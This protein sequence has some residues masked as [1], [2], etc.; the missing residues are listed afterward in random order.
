VNQK[1]VAF[2]IYPA[3]QALD[4][5][6]PMDA[7]AAARVSASAR[8]AVPGYDLITVGLSPRS[9]PTES[10]LLLTPRFTIR[11]APSFDTLIIPGGRGMRDPKVGGVVGRWLQGLPQLPRR[12]AA[13]CTGVFGL[14]SSGLLDGRRVTTHWRHA[15]E[16]AARFPSVQVHDDSLFLKDG[17]FYTS[18]GIT[19]G[20]DLSLALI[21]EDFG[22]SVAL[23]VAR[24]LVVYLKR[25]VGQ[26]QYSEPLRYQTRATDHFADLV[27]WISANLHRPLSVDTLATRMSMSPR[28]FARRFKSNFGQSPAAFV[29]I[30]RLE[31]SRRRLA[32]GR[33]YVADVARSVGYQSDAVFRRAFERR[34]GVPPSVYS[35]RF[36]PRLWAS[37]TASRTGPA[38]GER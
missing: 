6:G 20:I 24:E 33:R 29:E 19:A 38:A 1:R 31:E 8:A 4:I 10:G 2:L 18:A 3:I 7:F 28:H 36:G 9:V 32:T 21:E 12:I 14:A 25:E 34:F 15:R 27:S 17:P 11:T 30:A 13:I 16:L 37:K 5:A 23:S 22:P 35:N 26:G